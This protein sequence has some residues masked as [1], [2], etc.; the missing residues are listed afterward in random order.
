MLWLVEVEGQ[1]KDD[2]SLE[3]EAQLALLLL[4]AP[5]S[6]EPSWHE[7]GECPNCGAPCR[8]RRSPYCGDAC[9]EEAAFVRQLRDAVATGKIADPE[10]RL[11]L[12][13][14][15]WHVLGGG[16]PYR[17][18]LIPASAKRQVLKRSGGNCEVCGKPAE[19]FDHT[20]S[21]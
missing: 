2:P 16:R 8:D 6:L 10:R 13:Q 11:A 21:G 15:L 19:T 3:A 9:R 7:P 14:K 17:Q 18:S 12:G 4:R 1:L 5:G 20:G